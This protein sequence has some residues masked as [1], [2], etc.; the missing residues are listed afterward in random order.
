MD[1][2]KL[3]IW[4]CFL[5][6][7]C[8]EHAQKNNNCRLIWK[9]Q[10]DVCLRSFHFCFLKNEKKKERNKGCLFRWFTSAEGILVSSILWRELFYFVCCL[11]F[12]LTSFS[13]KQVI[14]IGQTKEKRILTWLVKY[15]IKKFL[16]K[17]ISGDFVTNWWVFRICL[18]VELLLFYIEVSISY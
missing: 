8:G 12:Y 13:N 18:A 6:L 17:P 15:L 11:I 7:F 1:W 3:P 2:T 16:E 4:Y 9:R 14:R 5:F 10:S